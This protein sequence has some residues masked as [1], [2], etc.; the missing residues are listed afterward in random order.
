MSKGRDDHAMLNQN[1]L[2]KKWGRIIKNDVSFMHFVFER[3]LI[4]RTYMKGIRHQSQ[5]MPKFIA[6]LGK[7]TTRRL[8]RLSKCFSLI[9]N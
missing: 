6:A 4:K 9:I 3:I 7:R 1:L 5:L 8:E 2:D